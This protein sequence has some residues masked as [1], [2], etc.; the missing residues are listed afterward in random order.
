M[1]D[2]M[3]MS[4]W[5]G[6]WGLPSINV[7]CLE[8]IAY[9]KF[10]GCPIKV[11]KH[12]NPWKSPTWQL[13]VFR[14]GDKILTSSQK[15]MDFLR[16]QNFNADYQLT[17]KQ[18]A[19]T[20]AFMALIEDKFYPALQY[21]FWGDGSN[22]SEFTR[23]LYAKRLPIP[24]SFIIPGQM[25][26]VGKYVATKSL[27]IEEENETAFE[28]KIFNDAL[29]CLQNLS[30]QLGDKPFFFGESPTTLDAVV[31]AHIAIV[32]RAPPLPNNKLKLH[33]SGFENLI[34]FCSRILQRYFPYNPEDPPPETK[35]KPTATTLDEDPY[36]RRKMWLSVGLAALAMTGYAL[37]S[38]L[39]QFNITTEDEFVDKRN[40]EL[41]DFPNGHFNEEYENEEE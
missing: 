28:N 24:L 16:E 29:Q 27:E 22:Y 15:I 3:E 11:N 34:A 20:L 38:G 4:T 19:D 8:V 10:S 18:G 13:P 12:N 36:Q 6:E 30:I 21:W 39:V 17:A 41:K 14:S 5:S 1:A 40:E 31:F 35:P 9:A 32:W 2:V 25:A 7:A 33:L 26:K 23:A 37:F